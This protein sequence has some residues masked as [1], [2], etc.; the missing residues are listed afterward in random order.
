MKKQL[1]L[2]T[3]LLFSTVY[4]PPPKATIAYQMPQLGR[5]LLREKALPQEKIILLEQLSHHHSF[6]TEAISKFWEKP[7]FSE[8]LS[9]VL[10]DNYPKGHLFEIEK[11][12][13]LEQAGYTIDGFNQLK[14]IPHKKGKNETPAKCEFDLIVSKNGKEIWIE[15]KNMN[16]NNC[17][18][19]QQFLNQKATA[20]EEQK[21]YLVCSKQSITPYWLEWFSDQGI[22]V[23]YPRS[24]SRSP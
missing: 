5:Y 13:E 23:E 18:K 17:S 19:K 20:Q 6:L 12:I 11:A 4:A 8:T 21:R 9:Q 22:E 15:C 10:G 14:K 24:P 3:S 2:F 1:F 16:W 7:G